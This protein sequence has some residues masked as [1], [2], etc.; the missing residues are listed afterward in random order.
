M[1]QVLRQGWNENEGRRPFPPISLPSKSLHD[2]FFNPFEA[3][4]RL[5]LRQ[6][7]PETWAREAEERDVDLVREH[8]PRLVDGKHK[9]KD[10]VL[11]CLGALYDAL[12]HFDSLRTREWTGRSAVAPFFA[13]ALAVNLELRCDDVGPLAPSALRCL[14]I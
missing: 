8:A 7:P 10:N 9:N 13:V 6:L 12:S 2:S 11:E 3:T 1:K 4:R 14:F 5:I